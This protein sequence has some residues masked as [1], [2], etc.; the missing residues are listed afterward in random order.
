MICTRD[1]RWLHGQRTG[2]AAGLRGHQPTCVASVIAEGTD[3]FVVDWSASLSPYRGKHEVERLYA[4]FLDTWAELSWEAE[5][6]RE[7]PGDRVIV[8]NHLRAVGRGS[9]VRVDARGTDLWRFREGRAAALRLF[10]SR[11]EAETAAA[12]DPEW[13]A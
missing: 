11:S 1:R 9:G 8:T 6:L 4:D 3:D 12:Q 7:L 10:Q 2:S 5:D 13:G